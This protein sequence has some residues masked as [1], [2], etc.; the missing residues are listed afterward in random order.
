MARPMLLRTCSGRMRFTCSRT[1]VLGTGNPVPHETRS[2]MAIPRRPGNYA[3]MR[4]EKRFAAQLI[5]F[6]GIIVALLISAGSIPAKG[7]GRTQNNRPA[8][9]RNDGSQDSGDHGGDAATQDWADLM[10][11]MHK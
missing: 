11:G 3:S 6:A 10:T 7:P 2:D 8:D 5:L 4:E 1:S 9:N